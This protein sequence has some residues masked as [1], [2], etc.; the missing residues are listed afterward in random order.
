MTLEHQNPVSCPDIGILE[1]FDSFCKSADKEIG[2]LRDLSKFYRKR[3]LIEDEYAK[4]LSRLISKHEVEPTI[5]E[6]L[7]QSW[8]QIKKETLSHS[9]FHD[10]ISQSLNTTIAEPIE[11]LIMDLEQKYKN[12]SIEGNKYREAYIDA[13]YKLR[14]TKLVC[15]RYS[16]E[17]MDMTS[18]MPVTGQHGNTT[19]KLSSET[20]RVQKR[21]L[22][23]AQEMVKADKDYRAAIHDTNSHQLASISENLPK[24]M[25]ELQRAEVAKIHLIKQN[26]I[27]YFSTFV[28][29][30][31]S[32]DQRVNGILSSL[33]AINAEEE[34]QQ[35]I[36]AN[37][38]IRPP[39]SPF[40]YEPFDEKKAAHQNGSHHNHH[41]SAQDAIVSQGS[42]A[43]APETN[44][45]VKKSWRLSR[46]GSS[47]NVSN[48][49][50]SSSSSSNDKKGSKS[51]SSS[52][53]L[54]NPM[55]SFTN[56]IGEIM[57]LQQ[58]TDAFKAEGIFRVPGNIIDINNGKKKLEEGNFDLDSDNVYNI[59]SILKLWLRDLKD[60][61][62]P[63]SLYDQCIMFK[64]EKDIMDIFASLPMCNQKALSYILR[65]IQFGT[66]TENVCTSMMDCNNYATVF[67][68]CFLRSPYSDPSIVL[69]NLNKEKEFAKL[70]IEHHKPLEV[71]DSAEA[72]MPIGSD[73]TTANV[74]MVPISPSRSTNTSKL[75][76]VQQMLQPLVT[77]KT[78]SSSSPSAKDS[79]VIQQ[80]KQLNN[81]IQ[82]LKQ[83]QQQQQQQDSQQQQQQ[84]QPQ[85][86]VPESPTFASSTSSSP[87]S[88]SS[89]SAVVQLLPSSVIQ[90]QQHLHQSDSPNL[91]PL[92][93]SPS[94][95][96]SS[97]PLMSTPSKMDINSSSAISTPA[98]AESS[99]VL[100]PYTD[101]PQRADSSSNEPIEIL[102]PGEVKK[103]ATN[104]YDRIQEE[105]KQMIDDN[106]VTVNQIYS[107]LTTNINLDAISTYS[108]MKCSHALFKFTNSLEQ[109]LVSVLGLSRQAIIDGIKRNAFV[110][111]PAIRFKVPRSVAPHITPEQ[112]RVDSVELLKS[113]L[114]LVTVC[115]NRCNQYLC[116][117][118]GIVMRMHSPETLQSIIDV[119]KI[120]ADLIITPVSLQG[121]ADR[122]LTF[123][124][125]EL[126]IEK[127][128]QLFQP[129]IAFNMI[130]ELD[131]DQMSPVPTPVG[132]QE[133]QLSSPVS[134]ISIPLE[135]LKLEQEEELLDQDDD[136][137]EEDDLITRHNRSNNLQKQFE[138]QQKDTG[139]NNA[140][141]KQN[142]L[143]LQRHRNESLKNEMLALVTKMNFRKQRIVD[144]QKT[145]DV[146][147]QNTFKAY[148]KQ[149][150]L[151]KRDMDKFVVDHAI[152]IQDNITLPLINGTNYNT[153]NSNNNSSSSSPVSPTKSTDTFTNI[154]MVTVAYLE[155]IVII[156]KNLWMFVDNLQL[157]QDQGNNLHQLIT[158]L[159]NDLNVI[160]NKVTPISSSIVQ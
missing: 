131:L 81:Q 69:G 86:Q 151:L 96:S 47:L 70:L 73:G 93:S 104:D 127:T 64:N 6:K 110:S 138:Q 58:Q 33:Q 129:I 65:M 43:V 61:L 75:P 71:D 27:R 14:K 132:V 16:K 148:A 109:H 120:A 145:V 30:D 18:N 159:I 121:P 111:P 83:Q 12:I 122:A 53:K 117:L 54:T 45:D 88:S 72:C 156:L 23:T 123:E 10:Q 74:N 108:A 62:I 144:D 8:E 97:S 13:V 152:P 42:V 44:K 94:T 146:E 66:K 7:R 28:N 32:Q 113:W 136:D 105:V 128:M 102:S 85:V 20:Q 107:D 57:A 34:I 90:Q 150:I 24:I 2:Y 143:L 91:T 142:E 48:N 26:F 59:S 1:G 68:P 63:T 95:G 38:L 84:Q 118:G 49:N 39:P 31:H 125:S 67:S 140:L 3:A 112:L 21:A 89:A 19:M 36:R 15:D 17:V 114:Q 35:F 139:A 160:C 77:P 154:C 79:L 98:P 116:F 115:V 11:G 5:G 119:V 124:Q 46:I 51:S 60:S 4:N 78:S 92:S 155:R 141:A 55:Y 157:Q 134:P 101:I 130:S 9:T 137:D 149:A 37:N 80:K 153:N 29:N 135:T 106:H 22:K 99:V 56:K 100:S 82:L 158:V 76:A 126:F 40:V 147:T 50:S 52:S 25:A 41:D 103:R 133:S 87:L